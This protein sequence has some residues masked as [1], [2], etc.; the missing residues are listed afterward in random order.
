VGIPCTG[1]ASLSFGLLSQSEEMTVA[2]L[3]CLLE[4]TEVAVAELLV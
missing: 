3:P 4:V 2:E 1:E